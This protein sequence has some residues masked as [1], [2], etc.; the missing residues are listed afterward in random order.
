MLGMK[1]RKGTEGAKRYCGEST[2]EKVNCYDGRGDIALR[3]PLR[4]V[5]LSQG[6]NERGTSRDFYTDG[7]MVRHRNM[8]SVGKPIPTLFGTRPCITYPLCTF[9]FIQ[10]CED[11]M[12]TLIYRQRSMCVLL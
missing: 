6:G 10:K 5:F 11:C 3:T 7:R 2:N 9:L 4:A 1:P 12:C 8:Y